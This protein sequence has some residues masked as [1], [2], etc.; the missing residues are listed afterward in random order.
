MLIK[1]TNHTTNSNDDHWP[2]DFSDKAICITSAAKALD[3][4]EVKMVFDKGVRILDG[5]K[6]EYVE[7]PQVDFAES[8]N[9]GTRKVPKGI[10]SGG[11]NVT[12]VGLNF[13]YIQDPAMYIVYQEKK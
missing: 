8:G 5:R 4:A 1:Q 11:V 12:V 9:T 7:D 10:P 3:K 13:N 2:I 6:Y